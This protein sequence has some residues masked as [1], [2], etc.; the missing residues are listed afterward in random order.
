MGD[1]TPAGRDDM[2]GAPGAK[3][4]KLLK[5]AAALRAAHRPWAEVAQ[6]VGRAYSSVTKWPGEYPERWARYTQEAEAE[7]E[8]R[9]AAAVERLVADALEGG[10]DGIRGLRLL[11]R[12]RLPADADGSKGET[13]RDGALLVSPQVREAALHALVQP[14]M[15]LVLEHFRYAAEQEERERTSVPLDAVRDFAERLAELAE[16]YVPDDQIAE[17]RRHVLSLPLRSG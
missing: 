8:E 7:R 10:A 3:M 14:A 6:K 4:R 2:P 13:G 12:G 11:A 5:E 16:T 9:F 1:L 15:K 17:F